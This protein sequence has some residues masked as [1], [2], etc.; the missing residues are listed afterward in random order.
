MGMERMKWKKWSNGTGGSNCVEVL[1]GN[2]GVVYVR[3]SKSPAASTLAF[4]RDEWNS[5]LDGVRNG[6]F[7]L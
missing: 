5:F 2:T 1:Y 6:A 7:D 4:S 3:D